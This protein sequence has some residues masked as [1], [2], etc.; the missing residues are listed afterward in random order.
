MGV[1][2]SAGAPR[3]VGRER[4]LATL[5][6]LIASA[7]GGNGYVAML[8][9]EPGI[10]KTRLLREVAALARAEEATVCFG[11]CYEG[12]GAA[13]YH[14][15]VEVLTQ[16]ARTLEPESLRRGVRES[17]A[18]VAG[19]VPELEWTIDAEP[20]RLTSEDQRFRFFD[21]VARLLSSS[22]RPLVVVL[23]DL[24]WSDP[25]A[26]DLLE[27]VA[28]S[29]EGSRLLV[30]GSH[31]DVELGS[32]HPLSDCLAE[33]NRQ[34][35]YEPIQLRLLTLD[36]TVALAGQLARGPVSLPAAAAIHAETSGNPFFIEEV[37]RELEEDGFD[38]GSEAPT[39]ELWGISPT[40]RQ[41]VSR[42]LARF[43]SDANRV[44]NVAAAF[45]GPFAFDVLLA[46]AELDEEALLE[47]L[48]ELLAARVI[49][50]ADDDAYEFAHPL[51]RQTLYDELSP[52]RRARVHRRVAQALEGAYA[53]REEEAAAELANQYNRSRSLPGAEQGL[54]FTLLAAERAAA[55]HA[56]AEAVTYLR[57][58]RNL[59]SSSAP[60]QRSE[61]LRRLALAEVNALMVDE[62]LETVEDALE[63][64]AEAQAER[65][66]VAD[67]LRV[68]AW[69]LHDAGAP[70]ETVT[71]LAERG[72][73]SASGRRDLTWARLKLAERPVEMLPAGP[74]RAGRWLG[75]DPEA[76]RIARESGDEADHARTIELMDWRSR[77]ETEALYELVKTWNDPT[78]AIHG[79]SVVVRDLVTKHGAFVEAEEVCIRLCHVGERVGSIPARAFGLLYLTHVLAARG[80]L[81]AARESLSRAGEVIDRL[82]PGH[83][84]RALRG[85]VEFM[86]AEYTDVDLDRQAR[87]ETE[88]AFDPRTPAWITLLHASAAAYAYARSGNAD[89]ARRYLGWIVPAL[90]KLEARTINQSGS[91]FFAAAA[92]W[93]LDEP[94]HAGQLRRSALDLIASDVVDYT[95][96]SSELTVAR[97][98]ALRG[99]VA[100]ARSWFDRARV[101]LAKRGTRHLQAI[102]DYDEALVLRQ[103]DPAA[104][105]R[106]LE[107]ARSEFVNLEMTGWLQR[108]DKLLSSL[109]GAY[110]RGLTAREAEVLRL[111]AHGRTNREIAA[112]LVISVHTVER[113]LA[114]IY[115]KI[116]ARNRTDA[117]AFAH[118]TGL[119]DT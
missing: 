14:P 75:F 20:E 54:P 53:G 16:Y 71:S 60:T 81:S 18:I 38:L 7:V 41:T 55:R 34:R 102:V 26:L 109:R 97:T 59:A 85:F 80:D 17:A 51:L 29:L 25:E 3:L 66:A 13:P 44:L 114:T 84:L 82:G 67:F 86:L 88:R 12:E 37:V 74:L 93:E 104:A 56:Y 57:M 21:A 78:A 27:Y 43:S 40:I 117:T 22:K 9:G 92:A 2:I 101:T 108:A 95:P 50:S 5:R 30:V 36:E 110:P 111:L 6:G 83:R 115:R 45:A 87:I 105:A 11:T 76:V 58:A 23:D 35:R 33:L 68:A 15:W 96:V 69:S 72:L 116:G 19:V 91:V 1:G 52:S 77:A 64:A 4:E 79:F 112:E 49:R 94:E 47:C 42:R 31:R 8:F 65:G 61:I 90:A 73:A 99:E 62:S 107:A 89:E 100:E 63:A 106:L 118:E 39:P 28:R 113:H 70:Q 103:K 10:G 46:A 98:T 24:Q 119:A 32:Q 48:E